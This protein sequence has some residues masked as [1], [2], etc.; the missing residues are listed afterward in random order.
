MGLLDQ[1]RN[2]DPEQKARD[3][4]QK[5]STLPATLDDMIPGYKHDRI[6]LIR[7]EVI[8]IGSVF[9]GILPRHFYAVM[10]N[11]S[12]ARDPAGSGKFPHHKELSPRP[13]GEHPIAMGVS[14]YRAEAET[15]YYTD[16]FVGWAA[17]T[18]GAFASW[19]AALL[20]S[21]TEDTPFLAAN[22][23]R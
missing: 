6:V 3:R 5:W 7:G 21:T 9:S 23:R 14:R 1:L 17:H 22:K 18:P 19:I 12:T 11:D 20:A 2:E 4:H 15:N 16:P 10:H 13:A 8:V